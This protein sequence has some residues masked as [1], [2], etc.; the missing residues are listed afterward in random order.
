MLLINL[1]IY[2]TG[3]Y[4]DIL[5]K[6]DINFNLER[7][8]KEVK[9]FFSLLENLVLS[10][11]WKCRLRCVNVVSP[12]SAQEKRHQCPVAATLL[13]KISPNSE[14]ITEIGMLTGSSVCNYPA[15]DFIDE[16][17]NDG[18]NELTH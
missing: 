18:L 15:S 6:F 14:H 4:V 11:G 3:N 8:F 7:I 9:I 13:V 1:F 2:K 5:I 16:N 17:Q 12:K 10:E